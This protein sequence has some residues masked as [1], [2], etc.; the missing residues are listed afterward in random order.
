MDTWQH[1]AAFVIQ[2]RPETDVA[3][4]RF[5]GRIEHIAST[6]TTRFR[7]LDELVSFIAMALTD[8]ANSEDTQA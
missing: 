2:F 6:R 4:G 3:A 5:E 8:I 7:S 1:K